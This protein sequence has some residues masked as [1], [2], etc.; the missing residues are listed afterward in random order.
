M[1]ALA[2][3]TTASAKEIAD[4]IGGVRQAARTAVTSV[5]GGSERMSSGVGRTHEAGR[6]FQGI[7]DIAQELREMGDR[8]EASSRDQDA[9]VEKVQEAMSRIERIVAEIDRAMSE[10]DSASSEIA[11]AAES[12][13][14]LGLA[15]HNA[16]GEQAHE[17]ELIACAVIGVK[18]KI[19]EILAASR[20][21]AA[22]SAGIAEVLAL[23][24]EAAGVAG[25]RAAEL[26]AVVSDLSGHSRELEL[27]IDRFR[28]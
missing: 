13:R 3:Q 24:R 21:Q 25:E 16:S 9:G 4:L 6:V 7:C 11:R 28:V 12:M 5:S 26:E 18:H 15:V 23:F 19:D 22:E 17:S 2:G 8:I 14:E 1:K 20:E 27:E 10:Q